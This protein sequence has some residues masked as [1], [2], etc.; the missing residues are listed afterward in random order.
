MPRANISQIA[1]KSVHSKGWGQSKGC[2]LGRRPEQTFLKKACI[3]F[4]IY[5]STVTPK[6]H[7]PKERVAHKE[8]KERGVGRVQEVKYAGNVIDG[9]RNKTNLLKSF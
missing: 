5:A 8:G 9:A 7:P 1:G 3:D 2:C 6:Y 4:W